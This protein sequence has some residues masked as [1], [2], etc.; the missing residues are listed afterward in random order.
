MA[1]GS[2]RFAH[3]AGQVLDLTDLGLGRRSSAV[4][5][6]GT[7]AWMAIEPGYDSGNDHIVPG[8]SLT[9]SEAVNGRA[10]PC[11]CEDCILYHVAEPQKHG[12]ERGTLVEVVAVAIEISG[13]P[14]A[15]YAS[16][17]LAAYDKL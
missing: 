17:A 13:G 10:L 2:Q 14:G 4:I 9:A 3:D 16:E 1:D 7:V 11:G 12:A 15:V 8:A 5:R 6:D